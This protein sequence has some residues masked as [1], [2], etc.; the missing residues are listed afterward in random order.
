[1]AA[2]GPRPYRVPI[3]RWMLDGKRCPSD[4]P[5]AQQIRTESKTYY[6]DLFIDDSGKPQRISLKTNRF[7][8]AEVKIRQLLRGRAL[9]TRDARAAYLDHDDILIL[10]HLAEWIDSLRTAGQTPDRVGTL[11]ARVRRIIHAAGWRYL[12]DVTAEGCRAA[13]ADLAQELDLSPQTRNHYLSH[14][15]QF[16]R[17]AGADKRVEGHALLAVKPLPTDGQRR[18]DRRC[19][20]DEEMARLF[21]HL[22]AGLPTT[23]TG[24]RGP[25]PTSTLGPAHRMLA[26]R[27]M[28]ATGFRLSELRSLQRPGIDLDAATI[29]VRAGYSKR[30]RTDTQHIPAWLTKELRAWLD[31]GGALFEAIPEGKAGAK[32]LQRDLAGAKIPYRVD[33]PDGPLWFDFH[34][35]RH[36]YVTQA[37]AIPGIDLKTLLEMTRHSTPE[38]AL[39]IYAKAKKEKVRAAVEQIPEP[40]G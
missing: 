7:R 12:P 9:E 27:V 33:G 14:A 31:A 20:T 24:K 18:R 4:T 8:E 15:K 32:M 34:S 16:L 23:R 5:G 29:T 21:A 11:D 25:L 40:P 3:T 38:L 6:A 36:Y 1:M 26:Y 17:W 35:L 37:A 19:P 13:L 2:Q 39:K 10:D 30:R 28:M 22:A